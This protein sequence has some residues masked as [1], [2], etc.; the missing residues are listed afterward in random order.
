MK[1][2][3]GWGPPVASVCAVI[4]ACGFALSKQ[5][6]A[7]AGI[8]ELSLVGMSLSNAARDAQA[9]NMSQADT[10]VLESQR[11]ELRNRMN[12]ASKPGLVQAELIESARK[13]G[14][15]VREVQ[16]IA[17]S[18]N[19]AKNVIV[20]PS[21][22]VSVQGNYSQI[23]EYMQICKEQRVPVRPTGFRVNSALDDN[24]KPSR[25]LRAELTMEAFRPKPADKSPKGGA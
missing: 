3:K 7:A 14:L 20:N 25:A 15:D 11:A 22:R 6:R 23:A 19:G 24:G 9:G 16:P 18:T 21:Y 10:K 12:E 1:S 17:A 2:V 4:L 8:H 13:T 5:N